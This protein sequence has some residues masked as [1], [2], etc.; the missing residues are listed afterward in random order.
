MK[1]EFKKYLIF[2]IVILALGAG[3]SILSSSGGQKNG[4]PDKK[5]SP[6][7]NG[8]TPESSISHAHGLAVDVADQNKLYIATHYGL[9]VLMNEKDLYRIGESRDDY[10]GFSVHPTEQNIFFSSGHPSTG[11]NSGFRKSL[12]GGVTWN[13][14]SDG[15][16]GP[17]DF[18]SMAVSPV[19]SNLIYGWYRGALQKSA[20]QGKNWEVLGG[21]SGQ[22]IQPY[23]FAADS[24]DENILYA[25]TVNG[26]IISRDKGANFA[27]LSKEL[28]G[29]AVPV[30]A[31]HPKDAKILLAFSEKLKGLGKSIDGGTTWKK[32]A[33]DWNG[34]GVFH[35]A[36]NRSN[37]NIVYALTSESVLYKSGDTGDTWH[38]IL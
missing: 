34:E 16:S 17:V 35:I 25:A 10:M 21:G 33:E 38:K 32:A 36:F 3:I 20:D 26:A 29:G 31:I 24:Q 30:I 15:I 7:Q 9:F 18:H 22:K 11:G 1:Q 8:L 28:D 19:N 6:A 13:K 37:P 5:I 23:A 27:P 12:D 14:V 2:S 4:L